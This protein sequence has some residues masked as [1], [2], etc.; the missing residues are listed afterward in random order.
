[1]T[2][3]KIYGNFIKSEP[4]GEGWSE[5]KKFCVTAEDGTKYLLRISPLSRYEVKKVLF[6][7]MERIA[8]L[9][10]PMCAPV[11]FGTC[12]D[13]VYSIHSWVE[14]EDLKKVLPLLSD[15]EQY[16][17]GLQAGKIAK[18][19]HSIAVP[20]GQEEWSVTYNRQ[21]D[22]KIRDYQECGLRFDGDDCILDYI[23]KARNLLKTERNSF[24]VWDYNVINMMYDSNGLKIIDFEYYNTGDP[25]N[26]FCCICWSAYASPHFATGQIN[27]YFDGEPPA[28]FFNLLALY[29][30]VLLLTLMSSWAVSSDFGRDVTVKL[31]QDMLKWFDNMRKPVPTWYQ[32]IQASITL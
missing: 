28:E 20:E 12:D 9:N 17:L 16:N 26:E 15:T 22:N 11:E 4:I 25:W 14:G 21:I 3:T 7:M 13:G 24:L 23:E 5:D 8:E 6:N 1:M 30:S 2:N 32:D 10:V 31:S 29:M 19:I 18:Q 27:G